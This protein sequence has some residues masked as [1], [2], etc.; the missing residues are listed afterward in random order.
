MFLRYLIAP[1]R[2]A[3]LLVSIIAGI[4]LPVSWYPFLSGVMLNV[5]GVHRLPNVPSNILLDHNGIEYRIIVFNH[6]TIWDH[7]VLIRHM[8]TLHGRL[9]FVAFS[10]NCFWPLSVLMR[11]SGCIITDRKGGTTQRIEGIAKSTQDT[12]IVVIAPEGGENTQSPSSPAPFRTGAFV[13]GVPIMPVVVRYFPYDR[14]R[15]E[16]KETILQFLMRRLL[17]QPLFYSVRALPVIEPLEEEPI[18]AFRDRA[19]V[20]M[21]NGL[22]SMLYDYYNPNL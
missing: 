11:K 9:R 5:I 2:A 3:A 18:E 13:H 16:K 17:G 14:L 22:A 15:T 8:P 20:L 1:F 12:S 10:K 21:E 19:K 4:F 6:P 7:L